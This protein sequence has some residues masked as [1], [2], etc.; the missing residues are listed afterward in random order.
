MQWKGQK[1]ADKILLTWTK[2]LLV[3]SFLDQKPQQNHQLIAEM[4]V[5]L[6]DCFAGRRV[7][8]PSNIT[9][10][11]FS[12]G[13][14]LSNTLLSWSG[15]NFWSTSNLNEVIIFSF[16]LP[17][18]TVLSLL[19]RND[20]FEVRVWLRMTSFAFKQYIGHERPG[21]TTF[22]TDREESA[23]E[24]FWPCELRGFFGSVPKHYLE[25]LI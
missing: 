5:F 10:F 23:A 11:T 18:K 14:K 19:W 22:L 12:F 20:W 17:Q 15:I 6:T 4:F 13:R 8:I 16:E 9:E 25:C 24:Y 1:L 21:L 7:K 3:R 2:S